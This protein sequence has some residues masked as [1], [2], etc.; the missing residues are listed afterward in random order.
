LSNK[1]IEGIS[2]PLTRAEEATDDLTKRIGESVSNRLKP[3][4]DR[5]RDL[6]GRVQNAL[7]GRYAPLIP[8]MDEFEEKYPIKE[9]EEETLTED[10]NDK[11]E[12]GKRI[13]EK[14]LDDTGESKP[15]E[16]PSKDRDTDKPKE[17]PK[18][19]EKQKEKQIDECMKIEICKPIPK[20][21]DTKDTPP[22]LDLSF[23]WSSVESS[24]D[25]TEQEEQAT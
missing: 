9:D 6:E 11:T 20:D 3:I 14:P 24:G 4:E 8:R 22:N 17:K 1:I 19:E 25:I 15:Y 2:R 16:T 5:L 10:E 21:E 23:A 12:L 7:I 18:Q 13:Q